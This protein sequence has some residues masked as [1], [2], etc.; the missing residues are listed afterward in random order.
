MSCVESNSSCFYERS[1]LN[2][3]WYE[4]ANELCLNELIKKSQSQ[5]EFEP[6][7]NLDIYA[8]TS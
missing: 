1:S 7:S 8:W 5:I 4:Y 6:V 2:I 3:L